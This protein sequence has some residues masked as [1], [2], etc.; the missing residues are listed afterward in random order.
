MLKITFLHTAEPKN[1]LAFGQTI[2]SGSG[3]LYTDI[4]SPLMT[5]SLFGT[6]GSQK[7]WRIFWH[8]LGLYTKRSLAY[9]FANTT[10]AIEAVYVGFGRGSGWKF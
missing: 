6:H 1:T 8:I 7:Q 4:C 5:K 9:C 3:A 2:S 10:I